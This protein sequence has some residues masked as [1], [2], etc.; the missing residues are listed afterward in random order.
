MLT[1]IEI[2]DFALIES[3]SLEIRPGFT[4]L[5]GETGAGKS[6]LIDAIGAVCGSR[7]TRDMVRS[8]KDLAVITAEFIDIRDSLSVELLE[9]FGLAD[10]EDSLLLSREIYRNGKSYARVNGRL[11]SV[12]ALKAITAGLLD[13]HGQHENQAIF[14]EDIQLL[15]LDRFGGE[16]IQKLLDRYKV[17]RNDYVAIEK[18]LKEFVTDETQK[19][20]LTNLLEY[21]VNEIQT[22]NPRIGE[23]T[24]LSERR[25]V[26]AHSEKIR[27][28]LE[29][30]RYLLN[31]ESDMPAL[32][33]VREAA[34]QLS[35]QLSAFDDYR[36]LSDSLMEITYRLDDLCDAISTE[37][38]K[39]EVYPGESKILD[40][41]LDTLYHLK[42]KY[43]GSIESVL[44]HKSKA[45]DRLEALRSGAD[46]A[47]KLMEQQ[48]EIFRRL[49]IAA[50]D[51]HEERSRIAGG[52]ESAIMV[53]LA[54]LG[55]SGTR[56]RVTVRPA[57][58]EKDFGADGQDT[59]EFQISPNVGEEL[60]P[61]SK[62]ASGG[63]ASRIM[64]AIKTILADSDSIPVLIFDE[65]DTGVSGKTAGLLGE[66]MQRI[67]QSHQVFCV[68]HM[69]Q[70]AAKAKN[71][72]HI[73]KTV[74]NERTYTD[75]RYIEAEER[76]GEIARLLSGNENQGEAFKLAQAMLSETIRP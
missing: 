55:M 37:I 74:R 32:P 41:R 42:H 21:Q 56:F 1:R 63:E 16:P 75:I 46:R 24:I 49:T 3:A 60:R 67:A 20:Q 18:A 65:V 39:V 25:K 44:A 45:Q 4:I 73:Q 30:A 43:G 14:H 9:E 6:I 58:D 64:L 71:H 59:V 11:T 5:T 2:S 34:N 70:I 13:I 23:D 48:S 52:L 47:K 8:D 26:I 33:A 72:I 7:V 38:D 66:K 50:K 35:S 10:E 68:T 76:I 61:L 51:L 29:K 22:A 31:G 28:T 57:D 62:I 53:E 15:L 17:I 54:E 36:S 69:A 40:D 12:S 19:Q 27:L